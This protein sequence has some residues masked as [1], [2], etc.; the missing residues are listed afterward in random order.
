MKIEVQKE[1]VKLCG[2]CLKQDKCTYPVSE[3]FEGMGCNPKWRK[4]PTYYK[5][6]G[7]KIING[8]KEVVLNE[9]HLRSLQ[10]REDNNDNLIYDA[11]EELRVRR[12]KDNLIT[13]ATL[14]TVSVCGYPQSTA[15][16]SF[17]LSQGEV[18]IRDVK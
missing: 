15:S 7:V 16:N 5:S 6:I 11:H 9:K 14:S 3:Y 18:A 2:N 17:I 12:N 13:Q 1:Y 8:D 10:F 4:N